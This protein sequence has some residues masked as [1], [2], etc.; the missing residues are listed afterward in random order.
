[1]ASACV[2]VALIACTFLTT[3]ATALGQTANQSLSMS[4][5]D[6]LI[7]VNQVEP[8]LLFQR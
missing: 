1:M 5:H 7:I 4:T 6:M 8:F 3:S 2:W